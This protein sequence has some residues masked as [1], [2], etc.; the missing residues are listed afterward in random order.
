MIQICK[1]EK[2]IKPETLQH[3][4]SNTFFL[5]IPFRCQSFLCQ[6]THYSKNLIELPHHRCNTANHI[7]NIE[8]QSISTIIIY[9]LHG[10]LASTKSTFLT[11]VCH[12]LIIH[13]INCAFKSP[14]YQINY[15]AIHIQQLH[16]N[17]K[18]IQIQSQFPNHKT[19]LQLQST[20]MNHIRK[21]NRGKDRRGPL[22][23]PREKRRYGGVAVIRE[24]EIQKIEIEIVVFHHYME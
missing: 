1:F 8:F 19:R 18:K 12:N 10:N 16:T 2:I 14:Q 4:L 20:N 21:Q 15:I 24:I 23:E 3:L 9:L 17:H 6:S 22:I 5:Q 7:I 11:Q 13:K